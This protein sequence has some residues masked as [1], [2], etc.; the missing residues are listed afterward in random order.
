MKLAALRSDLF[1]AFGW[2]RKLY[3]ALLI[4]EISTS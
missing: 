3:T 1:A 4:L 2:K